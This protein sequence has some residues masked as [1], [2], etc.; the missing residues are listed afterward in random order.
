[1]KEPCNASEASEIKN[2]GERKFEK[3]FFDHDKWIYQ[4]E[5]LYFSDNSKYKPDFHDLKRNV[6]IE[7]SATRQA[8]HANKLKYARVLKE[9]PNITLEIRNPKG[10]IIPK[11]MEIIE[12]LS[13]SI[14]NGR[15]FVQEKLPLMFKEIPI[16]KLMLCQLLIHLIL[17]IV[18]MFLL[19]D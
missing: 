12:K 1:M 19:L 8:F 9:F 3:H 18:K 7:V 17:I 13:K 16:Q 11:Y 14:I 4:P 5:Y 2:G 15:S 10:K 6:L